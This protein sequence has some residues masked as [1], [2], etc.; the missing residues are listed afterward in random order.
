VVEPAS[1]S[2]VGEELIGAKSAAAFLGVS[3]RWVRRRVFDRQNP[4]YKLRGRLAFSPSDLR[5]FR[6]PRRVEPGNPP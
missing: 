1:P 4:Y 2:Y 6:V 5:R 3:V